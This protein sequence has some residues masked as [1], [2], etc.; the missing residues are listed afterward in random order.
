MLKLTGKQPLVY[1][2]PLS[3]LVTSLPYIDESDVPKTVVNYMVRTE[4]IEI[5][6]PISEYLKDFPLPKT[7]F[8]DS[9]EFDELVKQAQQRQNKP[10]KHFEVPNVEGVNGVVLRS[11]ID[12]GFR[13]SEYNL[14][15]YARPHV[16]T[17][18]LT[19]ARNWAP[20]F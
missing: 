12:Y 13:N 5:N 6:Q 10:V 8:I 11:T 14:L 1:E 3:Y 9:L 7:P 15:R 20:S 17:P 18:T 16:G 4:A 2:H 19:S